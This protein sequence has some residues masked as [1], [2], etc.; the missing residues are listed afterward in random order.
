[1]AH[2]EAASA[3]TSEL[4][5]RQF[6]AREAVEGYYFDGVDTK[7]LRASNRQSPHSLAIPLILR[8]THIGT[9]KLSTTDPN[10]TWSDDE[11]DIAKAAAERTS[12]A[13]E[14]ARLLHEAQKRVAKEHAIGEISARIGS[15]N[16]LESL[17]QTTIQE[18]GNTLSDT[19]IAIQLKG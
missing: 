6:L 2:A 5:W 16:N 11:I 7:D 4:N 13:L 10:R 8:G 19:D 12:I 15:L 18:L 17:L 14:N 9:I 3:L 1:M